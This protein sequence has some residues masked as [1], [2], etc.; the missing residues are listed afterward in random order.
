MSLNPLHPPSVEHEPGTIG[1]SRLKIAFR[2]QAGALKGHG[3]LLVFFPL[4]PARFRAVADIRLQRSDSSQVRNRPSVPSNARGV[5]IAHAEAYILRRIVA[6]VLDH[7][8]ERRIARFTN[9]RASVSMTRA[10]S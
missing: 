10:L 2:G 9:T 4:R 7:G 3:A 1:R 5:R 6:D 8:R